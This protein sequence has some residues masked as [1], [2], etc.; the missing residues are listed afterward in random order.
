MKLNLELSHDA[1]YIGD[2]QENR[3]GIDKSNLDFITTLLTSNLYS[4][5]L[6]SFLR[7]TVANAY[8]SHIEAGTNEHILL[9]IED[10]GYS[11][12]TISIRDYGTGVSPERFE[13]IYKNIGSSTKRESNDYIGMFGIGRFSCLSCADVANITS[14]YNGRK[15]SYVMYKNGGGI[16]IDRISETEGDFKNGLEVSIKKYVF[17]TQEFEEAINALCLFDKLYV[18][19][20]GSNGSLKDYVSKFNTR[21]LTDFKTFSKCSLLS[22]YQNY[23][24][25]GNV[26]YSANNDANND[27]NTENG[28][29]I[30]LPIGTVDITPNREALQY[31][32]YT[33]RTIKQ[34]TTAVRQELQDMVNADLNGD[35]SLYKFFQWFC[36]NR[37]FIVKTNDIE[38]DISKDD[39][40]ADV[41]HLTMGGK[42]I[43]ENFDKFLNTIKY[44]GIEKSLVHKTVK[45]STYGRRLLGTSIKNLVLHKYKLVN[46]LDKVT[47]QVTWLYFLNNKQSDVNVV[48][49]HEGL[50]R[51][52]GDVV[53][54]AEKEEFSKDKSLIKEYVDFLFE[55]ISIDTISNDSIPQSFIE[56]YRQEQRNK[57]KTV[58]TSKV[59]I[60]R[61]CFGGYRQEYLDNLPNEG[62]VI[63]T[64]HVQEDS[65]LRE[66][67]ELLDGRGEQVAGIITVRN[68]F[69]NLFANNRRFITL[70]N[71][72]FLRNKL[73]SKLVTAK[74]IYDY[75]YK[76]ETVHL[77][78]KHNIPLWK[79]YRKKYLKEEN[80]FSYGH[81][82]NTTIRSIIDYYKGKGWINQY[83][84]DY[85]TLNKEEIEAVKDWERMKE[86]KFEIIQ[87]I[88]LKKFGRKPKIG[89][90]PVKVKTQ[91]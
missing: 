69:L 41:S 67:S 49:I 37:Y 57:R 77:I 27:L 83:D 5:P 8:D 16:N 71:F 28:L 56:A 88:A 73:L 9:L 90:L 70:E 60:R 61:Y 34:R 25:V 42:Q 14:Y 22:P 51:F 30:S 20:K 82:S 85:F 62:L 3:V 10:S 15:Y 21:S 38:I 13:Q 91:V 29:I 78:K 17:R 68:E 12:Y 53:N 48:L 18:S 36:D 86:N 43:P 52:K 87:M 1:E 75:F 6:E 7:E 79:E 76:L 40:K 44:R 47:K 11:T 66:L 46:K 65:A 55:N 63:Y 45:N 26:L 32:D 33:I 54:Y 39:V 84:I 19:Y 81:A 24:R 64:S 74:I 50:E 2:V 31:T 23:Y 72:M 59:P 58:D 89:L 4:K 35:M 80:S